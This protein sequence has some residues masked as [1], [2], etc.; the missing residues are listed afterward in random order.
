VLAIPT[1]IVA[2]ALRAALHQDWLVALLIIFAC[3]VMV[4][5][6]VRFSLATVATFAQRRF[7]IGESWTL[8]EG[9]AL[10]IFFLGF[11]LFLMIVL[12]EFVLVAVGM[13][14]V[15]GAAAALAALEA[16]SGPAEIVSRFWPALVIGALLLS[17][18][19]VALMAILTAPF[20]EVYREL[21]PEAT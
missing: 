5:L 20:A 12:I 7:A 2:F 14:A 17:V 8:T 16:V 1:A 19:G 18:F 9:K 4:W 21:A 15:G 6:V 3:G 11:L 13:A 10:K